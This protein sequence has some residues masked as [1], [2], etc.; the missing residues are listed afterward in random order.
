[1]E[2]EISN[3]ISNVNKLYYAL[4]KVFI[5]KKEISTTTKVKIFKGIYIPV[6]T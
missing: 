1:M 5:R 4:S 6:L 2:T 3:R